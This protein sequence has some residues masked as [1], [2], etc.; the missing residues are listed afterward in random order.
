M[1]SESLEGGA[2]FLD[3]SYSHYREGRYYTSKAD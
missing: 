3:A 1:R 2:V